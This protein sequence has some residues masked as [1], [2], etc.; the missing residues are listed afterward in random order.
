MRVQL[1][2]LWKPD[3]T[4]SAVRPE[5]GKRF[6]LPQM[7]TLVGGY[8]EIVPRSSPRAYCNEEGLL[9]KLPY[10]EAA[11][12]AFQIPLVGNVLQLRWVEEP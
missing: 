9:N 8:I 4:V 6:K 11:S 12:K 3:G 1:G 7:Q 5:D 10:N 2:Q